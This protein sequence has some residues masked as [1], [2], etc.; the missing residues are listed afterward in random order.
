VVVVTGTALEPDRVSGRLDPA[1]QPHGG[2]GGEYVIDGLGETGPRCCAPV[3]SMAHRAP[4]ATAA[5]ASSVVI[6]TACAEDFAGGLVP[7]VEHPDAE[8]FG[9]R[10][11]RSRHPRARI[12]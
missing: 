7:T 10:Q 3:M 5:A 9:Q 4:A 12:A 6:A 8:R 11:R 2:A 1:H